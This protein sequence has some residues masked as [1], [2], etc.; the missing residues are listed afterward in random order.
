VGDFIEI[1]L[2]GTWEGTSSENRGI[3]VLT[4]LEHHLE[5]LFITDLG[6]MENTTHKVFKFKYVR[7]VIVMRWPTILRD[8]AKQAKQMRI[9]PARSLKYKCE[10][11]EQP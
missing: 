2:L 1:L 9:F 8:A 10:R 11:I 6:E 3:D 7:P 5:L 4:V